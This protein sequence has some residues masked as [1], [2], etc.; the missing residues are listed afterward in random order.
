MAASTLNTKKEYY[1][2][3]ELCIKMGWEPNT[4]SQQVNKSTVLKWG[5]FQ[6]SKRSKRL[7]QK[8][9]W[10][11]F[12]YTRRRNFVTEEKCVSIERAAEL[13]ETTVDTITIFIEQ[14]VIYS[15]TEKDK[16]GKIINHKIPLLFLRFWY[17]YY[18]NKL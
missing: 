8:T 2:F 17:Q 6:A 1:S 15:I 18:S 13:Y 4:L 7:M 11:Y 16:E 9:A 14:G 12:V 3:P 5:L 10:D